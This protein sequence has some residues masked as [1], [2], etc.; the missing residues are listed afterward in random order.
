V[1]LSNVNDIV[2]HV[3]MY[4]PLL[5]RKRDELMSIV[6]NELDV[7]ESVAFFSMSDDEILAS[8]LGGNTH[9]L[10]S[11]SDDAWGTFIVQIACELYGWRLYIP[12][13]CTY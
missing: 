5:C 7:H 10:N 11:L 8:L 3:V 13:L 9:S 1:C 4:C 2:G 6:I 12:P